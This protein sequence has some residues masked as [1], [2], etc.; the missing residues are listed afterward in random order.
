MKQILLIRET[1]I[2]FY[3]RNE[4]WINLLLKFLFGILVFSLINKLEY[5]DKFNSLPIIIFMGILTMVLPLSII[6][7]LM[8]AVIATQL[9]FT[10]FELAVI[11]FIIL[12]CFLLFYIRIFPKESLLIFGILLAYYFKVPYTIVFI[13]A[14]FFG[15]SAI[16][17][18]S[19]GTFIWH[20]I[21]LTLK[22]AQAGGSTIQDIT[23]KDLLE[24]PSEFANLYMNIIQSI[25]NDQVWIISVII[26]SIT[27]I[28]MY[29]ISHLQ[30]DYSEYI[31]I[32]VGSIMNLI[33]FVLSILIIQTDINIAFVILSTIIS[34]LIV[35]LV[36]FFSRVLDYPSAE[37]VEFEDDDYYYYVKAIPKIT[38]K[39]RD[40]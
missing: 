27:I 7:F 30:I 15:L 36:E 35:C 10:S 16:V 11:V 1:I 22:L 28:V 19:I 31:S 23:S 39:N 29:I 38:V 18:I 12:M 6:T 33:G 37:K 34:A 9:F 13:G 20:F 3:R 21:P 8:I 40:I 17:P 32:G 25:K 24:I 4:R 14:I 2:I 26:F 5:I